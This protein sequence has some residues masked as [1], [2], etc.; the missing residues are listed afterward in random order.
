[1]KILF[2]HNNYASNNSG[3]EHAAEALREVLVANGHQVKWF[4]RFSDVISDSFWK[5]V[6]AFFSGMYNP[7]AIKELNGIL[8]DFEPDVVQLQNLYPFIS[9]GII[10]IIKR[11]G[12]PLVM[13]CPNYRL[14]C[15]TGLHL[16][17]KG[18]ICERC[19][20]GSRELNCISKN[21]ENNLPKS[22]GYALRNFLARTV[23]GVTRTM[24]AYIVQT[25]FQRQKFIENGIPSYKLFILPGLTPIIHKSNN[26]VKPIYVSFIGRVSEEKGIIEF[27]NAARMLPQIP[28][29]VMGGLKTSMDYLRT[30]SPS[31]VYWSGFVADKALDK[32]IKQSKFVVVPSKWY[33][34]F[35]NVITR[36]MQHGKPVITSD[37]G[38]MSDIIDN[39]ENGLLVEPG[40]VE[41]LKKA[42]ETLYYDELKCGV[43]GENAKKKASSLYSSKNIYHD[44][45]NLYSGL[46]QYEQNDKTVITN[47]FRLMSESSVAICSIVRNSYKGLVKNIPTIEELRLHFKHSH[48][49]V[50]END[51]TDKT[52]SILKKWSK[53]SENVDVDCQDF[54]EKTIPKDDVNG[55]NKYFSAF[56]ISKMARYR[57]QYLEALESR[58]KSFDFVIVIDLDIEKFSIEGIA[59]SFGLA[60]YWDAVTANGYSYS[61][62][63][64]KRYHDT[65]A[66][67]GNGK[68]SSVQNE[69]TIFEN[70]KKWAGLKRG[71]KLVPVYSAFG[72]LAIY[73][74]NAIAEK[75][76]KTIENNDDRVQVRCEHFSIHH[77]MQC[78][79]YSRIFINPN[80]PVFY[81]K[82]TFDRVRNYFSHFISQKKEYFFKKYLKPI[83][84]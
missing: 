53:T 47:G 41:S 1:M 43:F 17:R 78:D 12:I 69:K 73:H 62:S 18:N 81:E 25:E 34:G 55:F 83:I 77:L 31:N 2:I 38:A 24:D 48:V 61:P 16:D 82:I 52:K 66:L 60:N 37:L 42:I 44:L 84:S 9:P 74:Y 76:Y 32:A 40:K 75:R 59:H 56:R 46:I 28:F 71:D 54:G 7:K 51:S 4:R 57:N 67:V 5:K 72:G 35:P 39:D 14:F 6:Q 19:L 33:E 26:S 11:R 29:R 45:I 63:F 20:S 68:E 70:Q 23:W 58:R 65:Y 15:P 13:R 27:L 80:M 36:A 79:G 50:F 10:R 49:I 30:S 22:I 21:C 3:E 64:R 8:E